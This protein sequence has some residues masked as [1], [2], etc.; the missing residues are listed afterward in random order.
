MWYTL[1]RFLWNFDVDLASRSR[2]WIDNQHAYLI[3]DKPPLFVHLTPRMPLVDSIRIEEKTP[4]QIQGQ[5]SGIRPN[6]FD[7]INITQELHP[8]FGAEVSGID[9]SRPISEA[10]FKEITAAVAKVIF[11]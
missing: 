11:H 4:G 9:F 2:N 8:T 7:L 5:S 1:A 6:M 10:V 3:W